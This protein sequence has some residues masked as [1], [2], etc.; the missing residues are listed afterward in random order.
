MSWYDD[1]SDV[2]LARIATILERMAYEE[3]VTKVIRS[4]IVNNKIDVR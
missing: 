2:E 3:D 4:L 1:P